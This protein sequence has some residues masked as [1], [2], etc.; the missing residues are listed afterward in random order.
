[1]LLPTLSILRVFLLILFATAIGC[2]GARAEPTPPPVGSSAASAPAP[3]AVA[4]ISTRR[5]SSPG[6]SPAAPATVALLPSPAGSSPVAPPTDPVEAELARLTLADKVGQLLLAGFEGSDAAGA[7]PAI[8]ELRAG[9]IALLANATTADQA[10]TLTTDL[11]RLSAQAGL[12]PLLIAIDH[13]GGAVQRIRSG[14]TNF[15]SNWLLGQVRPLERAVAA[16]CSRG[17]IHGQELAGIGVS[18]NLAPVLDVWDNPENTVIGD[19][20]YSDDPSVAARLGAAYIE[21]MQAQGVLAVGKHFP[22][23]GSSTEDSHLTLP[24]V[25]HDRA[26]LD[27]VELVPFR[28]AMQA[29]VA[30]IMT[31][32]VSYPLVDPQPDRPGSLSP[33]IVD[34]LLR[35]ELGYQGLVV[36]DD[37]GAM[38]AIT[39]RYEAGEAAVR[40][41][42]AGADLLIVVGPLDRQRRT[43]EAIQAEVGR[44]ISPERLDASVRRVLRAKLQAGLLGP[45][46][47][48]LVAA[49]PVCPGS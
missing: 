26:R 2:G 25:R 12:P 3:P 31:A 35:G 46:R 22:G 11:Q 23:H 4:V 19:R 32:H 36:T 24:V 7:V 15:G 21:A 49:A 10:R 20:S 5:S 9:G 27:A 17:A 13:E 14:V 37:M 47:E 42:Q 6:S 1:M 18:M 48:S 38:Q 30:A 8:G 45:E 33:V 39:G 40:A 44:S 29:N 34:G 43:V 41:I 28:A 16:A